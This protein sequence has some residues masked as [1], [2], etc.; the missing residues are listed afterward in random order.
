MPQNTLLT[1]WR[2]SQKLKFVAFSLMPALL[3]LRMGFRPHS[4]SQK[5]DKRPLGSLL[6]LGV[7][8]LTEF[9]GKQLTVSGRI[10]TLH[11][12]AFPLARCFTVIA[13][14]SV[15]LKCDVP[16]GEVENVP[17]LGH[18]FPAF[19]SDDMRLFDQT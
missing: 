10:F 4:T 9:K 12:C 14:E 17:S 13:S 3:T 8:R 6:S 16:T 18:H 5:M 2:F 11:A 19:L 7:P 1:S 15:G